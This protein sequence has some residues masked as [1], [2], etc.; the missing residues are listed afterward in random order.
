MLIS[1]KTL[2]KKNIDPWSIMNSTELTTLP[3][4]KH[5]Y[6]AIQRNVISRTSVMLLG[7]L[8]EW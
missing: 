5:R 7:G 8:C 3:P 6:S 1:Q 2:G 4:E